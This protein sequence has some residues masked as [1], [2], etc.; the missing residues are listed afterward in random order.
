MGSTSPGREIRSQHSNYMKFKN[1]YPGTLR[2]ESVGV[3]RIVVWCQVRGKP[4]AQ[5]VEEGGVEAL[6]EKSP[7]SG[8]PGYSRKTPIDDAVSKSGEIE[9]A[10]AEHWR[11]KAS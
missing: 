1:S 6:I 2:P 11:S 9:C 10:R 8:F 3:V 4:R 5:A 7:G